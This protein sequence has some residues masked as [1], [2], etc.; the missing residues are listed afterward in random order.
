MHLQGAVSPLLS[1]GTIPCAAFFFII[2]SYLFSLLSQDN[3]PSS[4]CVGI[5]GSILG[6]EGASRKGRED[7]ISMC[8]NHY[9]INS[10]FGQHDVSGKE[11]A[12]ILQT[13]LVVGSPDTPDTKQRKLGDQEEKQ[14]EYQGLSHGFHV[15]ESLSLQA[16]VIH[17]PQQPTLLLLP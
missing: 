4:V 2:S 13:V 7:C 17:Q 10:G 14:R 11:A 9:K 8:I 1:L 15:D 6:A 5:S 3:T 12:D 16:P